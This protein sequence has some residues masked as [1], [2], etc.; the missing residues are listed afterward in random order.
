MTPEDFPDIGEFKPK[1][2]YSGALILIEDQAGRLLLQLRDDVPGIFW[3]GRWGLFGGA[4]EPGEDMEQAA[5]REVKEEVGLTLSAEQLTPF[6]KL[7][8]PPPQ[9]ATLYVF[10]TRLNIVPADIC[11]GEGAGFAFLT[12]DQLQRVD[13]IDNLQPVLKAYLAQR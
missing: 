12:P 11:L 3:P 10:L 4:I 7:T 6:C 8:S 5:L 13:L 9:E 1:S 2:G